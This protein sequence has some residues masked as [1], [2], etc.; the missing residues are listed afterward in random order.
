MVRACLSTTSS[1]LFEGLCFFKSFRAAARFKLLQQGKDGSALVYIG[2]GLPYILAEIVS[3]TQI[4]KITKK[5][6]IVKYSRLETIS[7]IG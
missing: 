1:V 2:L 5:F 4:E 6:N 3:A 7:P